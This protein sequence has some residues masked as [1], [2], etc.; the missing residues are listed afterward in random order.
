MAAHRI[1]YLV[2]EFPGQTHNF[3][4]REICALRGQGAQVHLYS[5][6]RPHANLMSTS[7]GG[8][9][10]AEVGYLFPVPPLELPG[11][12]ATLLAAGPSA[13]LHCLRGILHAE[14]VGMVQ[15][16]RM[17]GMLIIAARLVR[18]ARREGWSHLHVHSCADAANLALFARW[19]GG[20]D[21]SLTLHNPLAVYGGN[22]R[23]KWQHA[24]FGL[25]ITQAILGEV[26]RT[27]A[28]SLPAHLA[29]APMGVDLSAFSR[30]SPYRPYE[31]HGELRLFCCA[32]LNPG[33]GYLHLVEAVRLLRMRG[34]QATLEIAGEDDIGG[35]GH[36]REI[37]RRIQACGI[38]GSVKLLGA[39][40]EEA[41][42]ERLMHAHMFVLA[43][44]E[45]PL[46]V[47]IM[48]AMAMEVP[49]VATGAGGV[50]ELISHGRD[51]LLVAPASAHAIASA[52][53]SVARNPALAQRLSAC[54]RAT[55]RERFSSARSARILL[56]L[57]ER[58]A[59]A[60]EA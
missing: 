15:R 47:S 8:E 2:P 17:F 27:L 10:A 50:P 51:G 21:Y 18:E 20:P 19:L 53:E 37:E 44:L 29:V 13:W 57:V 49:V 39:V 60:G 12:L 52:V 4:W 46:G 41:V 24:R 54:S 35:R 23:Q 3:F 7:W 42:R 40:A 1:A 56:D 28:G 9:V 26:R 36:R 48:E 43:S 58:T 30:S 14:S 22:Q 33:K 34:L 38:G 11:A 32:R 55:V 16:L 6:R 45:E 5:T 31:G 59:V 25:V